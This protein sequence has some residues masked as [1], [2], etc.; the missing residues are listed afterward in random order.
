M[1]FVPKG[2]NVRPRGSKKTFPVQLAPDGTPCILA[3]DKKPVG[4]GEATVVFP[5]DP[6]TAASYPAS[7]VGKGLYAVRTGDFIGVYNKTTDGMM[8]ESFHID[9]IYPDHLIAT[10]ADTLI[11]TH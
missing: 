1:Y 4:Q 11:S 8:L 10:L 2:F 7:V 3:S 9:A 5:V 6:A